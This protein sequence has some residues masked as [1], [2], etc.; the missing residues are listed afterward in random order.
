MPTKRNALPTN[1]RTHII[2]K[3]SQVH[4]QL[5]KETVGN[6]QNTNNI[7]RMAMAKALDEFDSAE[8]RAIDKV[9]QLPKTAGTT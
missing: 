4:S 7:V 5:V 3:G 2:A 9:L 1:V 6:F 8:A